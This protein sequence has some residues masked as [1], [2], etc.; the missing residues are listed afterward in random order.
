[1]KNYFLCFVAVIFLA[2]AKT[3]AAQTE[4]SVFTGA[5]AK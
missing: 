5:E 1:M 3:A 2:F 4:P